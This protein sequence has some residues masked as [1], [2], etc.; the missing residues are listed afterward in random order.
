MNERFP[1]A[2]MV[3]IFHSL[4]SLDGNFHGKRD[5]MREVRHD[6]HYLWNGR[7]VIEKWDAKCKG[8]GKEGCL[9]ITVDTEVAV[10]I[11]IDLN[12]PSFWDR[13]NS[14]RANG[15]IGSFHARWLSA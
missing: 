9:E 2:S 6:E 8:L 11:V 4:L 15:R 5:S 3:C 12:V 14:R 7:I 1:Y 13:G 10:K